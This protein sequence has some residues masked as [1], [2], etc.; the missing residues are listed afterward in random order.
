M[1]SAIAYVILGA[2]RWE[3]RSGYEV[4]QLVDGWRRNALAALE[5]DDWHATVDGYLD[6]RVDAR[7]RRQQAEKQLLLRHFE[8]EDTNRQLGLGS[9]VLRHVE[10]EA[11]LPHR[12]PGRDDDQIG[13]LQA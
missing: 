9:H 6:V 5:A 7:L 8:A 3:P 2:L 1:R 13:R 4:K 11:G 12:R 10:D